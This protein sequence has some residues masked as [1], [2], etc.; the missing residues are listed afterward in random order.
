MSAPRLSKHDKDALLADYRE[1]ISI[2]ELA[3]KYGVHYTYPGILAKRRG[4]HLR[5]PRAVRR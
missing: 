3:Q 2:H 1:G 5:Q 4:V